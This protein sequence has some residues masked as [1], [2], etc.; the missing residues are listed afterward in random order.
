MR[1]FCKT[2]GSK[3][4]TWKVGF[5]LCSKGLAIGRDFAREVCATRETAER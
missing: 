3:S 2:Q 4:V 5:T 1:K